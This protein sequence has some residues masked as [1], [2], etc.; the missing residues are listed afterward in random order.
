MRW[1][2]C[3]FCLI[4]LTFASCGH[5]KAAIPQ[6]NIDS[7]TFSSLTQDV[8][9][10]IS[11]SGVTKYKLT[12][13]FWYTYDS[14]ERMWYFPEG[15]YLEQF[16]T[17]FNIIASVEADTAYYYQSRNLWELKNNVRIKNHKGE[18]FYAVTLYWD[19]RNEEIYSHD[20]IRIIRSEEDML[21]SMYGFKSN[22]MMTKYE[23]YSS[24]GQMNVKDEPIVVD[25][26]PT[27]SSAPTP[28]TTSPGIPSPQTPSPR[29][30]VRPSRY[31]IR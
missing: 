1:C 28:I 9:T 13:D 15:I 19:E 12:A 30:S 2:A 24:R 5:K 27:S 16:D 21:E 10:L 18:K 23:L 22:Q 14:P 26:V 8:E 20:P 3:F 11:D 29:D 31:K 4:S 17:L 7:V 25:S 6:A